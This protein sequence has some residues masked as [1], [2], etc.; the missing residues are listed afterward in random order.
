M[1]NT[2]R[3]VALFVATI[4]AAV[5][6]FGTLPAAKASTLTLSVYSTGG[7][8]VQVTVNGDANAG[9]TLYY[10]RSGYNYTQSQYIGSTN[11]SGY[12]STT[13]STSSYGI[14]PGSSVYVTVN[15]LTSQSVTWPYSTGAIPPVGNA[16]WLSQSSVNVTVG[17]S[18][19][20]TVSGGSMPYS[21]FPGSP[22]LYQTV[23]G[24]NT[25]TITGRNNGTDTL[26]VCSTNSQSSCA[27]LSISVGSG[28]YPSG[29]ISLSQNS[30]SLGTS[31]SAS[32][33]I[34]G[35]GSFYVSS[36]TNPGVVSATVSGSTLSV[37]GGSSG[38]STVTVCS[39]S[40]SQCATLYVTVNYGYNSTTTGAV[41]FSRTNPSLGVNQSTTVSVSGGASSTY[42]LAYVSN[43]SVVNASISGSSLYLT[44]TNTGTAAIVVCSAANSCSAMTVTV[45]SVQGIS[46][47]WTY[48]ASENGYCSFSGTQLVRYGA[49][50][51]YVYRTVTGG[52]S[53]SNTIF[54][55]PAFGTVKQCAYGG[56]L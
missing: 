9:V 7:D 33:A 54:G 48:C 8:A 30:L 2:R 21:L 37:Y 40:V 34:Y 56:S 55:D 50:G 49:N 3:I 27:T 1:R 5:A 17:Q 41:T 43:T 44:G 39:N 14:N 45:G 47:G 23:L 20:V 35:A 24:Q 19:N 13:I 46:T 10:Y 6:L 36:T 53:C 32:V 22:N 18:V 31:G 25:L 38:T 26:R 12:F 16:P 28:S 52:T 11:Y 15:G 42:N 29:Q 4:V 51:S